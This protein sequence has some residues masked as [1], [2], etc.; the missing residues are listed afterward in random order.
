MSF[1]R[2]QESSFKRIDPCLRRG[3]ITGFCFS[4]QALKKQ[5][6]N[7]LNQEKIMNRA[8]KMAWFTLIVAG[9]GSVLSIIV[10]ILLAAKFGFPKAFAGFACMAVTGLAGFAPAI[11]KKEK[12]QVTFDERDRG[13]HIKSTR[14]GFAAS[15]GFV[16]LICMGTWFAIGPN[17]MITVNLLPNIFIGAMITMI[18][19]QSITILVEY[20]RGGKEKDNE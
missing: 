11:F 12:R 5:R 3:D 10:V 16:G 7:G 18:I 14:A 9:I 4:Q 2:M 6:E 15:Y 1:L 8:Q 13:I 17:G 20:G 19:V